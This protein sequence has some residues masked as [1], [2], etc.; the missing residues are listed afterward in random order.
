MGSHWRGKIGVGLTLE[1]ER[2]WTHIGEGEVVGSHW[3]GRGGGLTLGRKRWWAHIGEGEVVGSYW[4]W[5]G[6]GLTLE[7]ER[8]W[9]HIGD[10]EVVWKERWLGGRGGERGCVDFAGI[11]VNCLFVHHFLLMWQ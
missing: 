2:W 9:A 7:M 10:G 1:R 4:R 3:R 5:R 8:W 11:S 6:G